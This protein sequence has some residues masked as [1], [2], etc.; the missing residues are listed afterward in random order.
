MIYY[1]ALLLCISP[2]ITSFNYQSNTLVRNR[3]KKSK[4]ITPTTPITSNHNPV[5]FNPFLSNDKSNNES[6]DTDTDTDNDEFIYDLSNLILQELQ[7]SIEIENSNDND[8][9]NNHI[10]SSLSSL[11]CIIIGIVLSSPTAASAFDLFNSNNK[12]SPSPPP[13]PTAQLSSSMTIDRMYDPALFQPVCPARY[14]IVLS[15]LLV[16]LIPLLP[17]L[18]ILILTLIL[19]LL[20]SLLPLLP[21]Q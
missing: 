21:L 1:V 16:L 18:I 15:L 9:N 14:V 13:L 10:S 8:D 4:T 6:Y 11:F 3:I 7:E 12:V 17:L 19:S 20:L 2:L 5:I